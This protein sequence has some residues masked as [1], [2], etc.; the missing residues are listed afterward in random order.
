MN[1][2]KV[3]NEPVSGN[4]CSNC[5]H[6]VKLKK[7]DGHYIIHEITDFMF[8]NK[9]M[10]YT[11]KRVLIRPGESVRQFINEDRHRFVKPITFIF[12]TS[13]FYALVNHFFN[14]RAED[15]YLQQEDFEGSS[16]SVIF[17]WMLIEY[18]GYSTI[19][20]GLF[21]AFWIKIFFRKAG[22]NIFEIFILLCFVTGITTLF[23]SIAAFIQGATHLK[24]IEISTYIMLIYYIWAI[25]QFFD[26]KKVASYVKTLLS[27]FLGSLVLGIL[28]Y[29]IGSIIDIVIN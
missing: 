26:K 15:Y 19:F 11:I 29:I 2:C 22:Y 12:I 21:M 25:G 3:C 1:S 28:I 14:I 18:P 13:L 27:Y 5:G 9:G 7:I 16:I 17:H 4:Y 24:L 6:P 23:T 10:I 8:A 20:T